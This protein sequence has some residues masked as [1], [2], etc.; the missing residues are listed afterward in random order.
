MSLMCMPL[1]NSIIQNNKF[2]TRYL[3]AKPSS[4]ISVNKKFAVLIQSQMYGFDKVDVISNPIII[5]ELNNEFSEFVPE[6]IFSSIFFEIGGIQIDKLS[7]SNEIK[8]FQQLY[9]LEIKRFGNKVFFPIPI[10]CLLKSNGILMPKCTHHDLKLC[11]ECSSEPSIINISKFDVRFDL[12]ILDKKTNLDYKQ[13]CEPHYQNFI[14]DKHFY[15]KFDNKYTNLEY[16]QNFIS[17]QIFKFTQTQFTGLETTP[18]VSGWKMITGFYNKI[19]RLLFHF[20][21]EKTKEIYESK[22]FDKI[23]LVANG[24]LILE[25]DYETLV[26]QNELSGYKF[27]KGVYC[28]DLIQYLNYSPDILNIEFTELKCLPCAD[29]GVNFAVYAESENYLEYSDGCCHIITKN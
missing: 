11:F 23:G 7:S 24:E 13:I 22:M 5:I 6:K 9:G 15:Y 2:I 3:Y 28:I 26:Y 29:N 16:Y 8:I 21:F 17:S 1:K 27:N 12:T 18:N 10:N 19:N 4:F 20:E 14:T 25:L